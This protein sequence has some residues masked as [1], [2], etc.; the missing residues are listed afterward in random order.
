MLCDCL[1]K[2]IVV[3]IQDTFYEYISE[4]T[5]HNNEKKGYHNL[6]LLC[7]SIKSLTPLKK[8]SINCI[9]CNHITS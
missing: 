4:N 5:I 3:S 9:L 1:S 7:N 2:I 8:N 6:F